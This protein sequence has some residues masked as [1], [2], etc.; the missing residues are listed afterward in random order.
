VENR[1]LVPHSPRKRKLW[2][3]RSKVGVLLLDLLD[4]CRTVTSRGPGPR[5]NRYR[6]VL[7][8][9]A[10]GNWPDSARGSH[11][12]LRTARKKEAGP[13]GRGYT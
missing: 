3:T 5:I 11:F 8:T 6:S 7:S 2:A 4:P 9:V 13:A 10:G 12:G 1:Q